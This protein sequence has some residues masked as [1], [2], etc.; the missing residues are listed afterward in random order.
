MAADVGADLVT[1]HLAPTPGQPDHAATHRAEVDAYRAA[2]V[3]RARIADGSV[4]ARAAADGLLK[5]GR[6]TE[7][8]PPPPTAPR[9]RSLLAERWPA[10]LLLACGVLCAVVALSAWAAI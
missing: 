6:I 10:F 7:L 5:A 1:R 9:S 2:A 3:L 4:A 8:N